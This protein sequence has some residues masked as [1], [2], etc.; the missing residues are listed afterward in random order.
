MNY[1]EF[2][3]SLP[4]NINNVVIVDGVVQYDTANILNVRLMQGVEAFDFTG[5]TEVYIEIL[6]PDGTHIQS[7]VTDDESVNSDNNPYQIQIVDPAEGRISFTLSGQ[8][9]LLTGTHFVQIMI[10]SDGK[11]MTT[12]RVNYYVGDTLQADDE[13]GITSTDEYSSLRTLIARN[14][15]IATEE[16]TRVDAETVRKL[17]E[18]ARQERI[19]ELESEIRTYLE[20]AVG[21]VTT[22][23]N[24]MTQAQKFAELAQNPSKELMSDLISELDLASETY[25]DTSVSTATR[26]FD[27]GAYTDADSNKKL[28]QVR[29]G[30]DSEKPTLE[31][32]ELGFS[33]DTNIL[34]IGTTSGAVAVNT[35]FVVSASAPARTDVLWVDTGNGGAIKY[36]DG[37]AWAGTNTAVFA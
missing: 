1:K 20:N 15:A 6:K 12:A 8:A 18:L 3:V 16:R 26:N 5:Y 21:Y 2:N 36:Y 28:L 35:G 23:E 13:S 31:V 22:T 29:R 7:C 14:S 27:A 24:Y 17:A 30:T 11:I 32:G 10:A 37:S 9:T 33:T 34:Y 19:D 25:V 4:V